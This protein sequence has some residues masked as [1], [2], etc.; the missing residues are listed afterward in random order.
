MFDGERVVIQK[1][2]L[3]RDNGFLL[4]SRVFPW[5]T[6]ES[7]DFPLISRRSSPRDVTR[8]ADAMT[9]FVLSRVRR[10]APIS[11]RFAYRQGW[12]NANTDVVTHAVHELCNNIHTQLKAYDV[13]RKLFGLRVALFPVLLTGRELVFD[14]AH[15]MSTHLGDGQRY[16]DGQKWSFSQMKGIRTHTGHLYVRGVGA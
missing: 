5:F 15:G 16:H 7:Q 12:D 11:V 3:S 6:L 14:I 8:T 13:S 2:R 9:D 4:K 10:N 1:E